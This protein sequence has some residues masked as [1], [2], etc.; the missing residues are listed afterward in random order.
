MLEKPKL[1]VQI[2]WTK[3]KLSKLKTSTLHIIS[4]SKLN[5]KLQLI[6]AKSLAPALAELGSAQPQLVI[7]Y[8]HF[9]TLPLWFIWWHT[10]T[11]LSLVKTGT[12]VIGSHWMSHLQ[13]MQWCNHSCRQT[14]PIRR[15]DLVHHRLFRKKN[16]EEW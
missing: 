13:R 10:M 1:I 14:W 16:L 3:N 8:N 2:R 12:I 5:I 7:K 4:N 6:S 11:Q 9:V 15:D